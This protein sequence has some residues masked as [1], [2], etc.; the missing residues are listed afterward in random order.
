MSN[1]DFDKGAKKKRE[2]ERERIVKL[3]AGCSSPHKPEERCGLCE[4]ER[5]LLAVMKGQA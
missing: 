1:Y 4:R 5:E 2:F 3:L